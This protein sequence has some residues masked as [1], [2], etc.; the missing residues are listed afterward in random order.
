MKSECDDLNPRSA[1]AR[2]PSVPSFFTTP[3]VP[4]VS[5]MFNNAQW[6]TSKTASPVDNASV[7]ARYQ[8]YLANSRSE[9]SADI[10]NSSGT[11]NANIS[12]GQRLTEL[13][14]NCGDRNEKKYSNNT[15]K[16][17][18]A[19]RN[20]ISQNKNFPFETSKY[21]GEEDTFINKQQGQKSIPEPAQHPTGRNR[22]ELKDNERY[23]GWRTY[24]DSQASI[25][26]TRPSTEISRMENSS[27]LSTRMEMQSNHSHGNTVRSPTNRKAPPTAERC[28]EHS[29][30]GSRFC[31]LSSSKNVSNDKPQHCDISSNG[32]RT[33]IPVTEITETQLQSMIL[34]IITDMRN[35]SVQTNST[36]GN[37]CVEL[38]PSDELHS[39]I[40]NTTRNYV[41]NLDNSLHESGEKE[42]ALTGKQ[43]M[44]TE[45]NSQMVRERP[46]PKS[47]NVGHQPCNE[48]EIHS[49]THCS[50]KI[51]SEGSCSQNSAEAIV[52]LYELYHT[53]ADQ[54]K[55]MQEKIDKIII[56]QEINLKNTLCSSPQREQTNFS[57]E[58]KSH[59]VD[60]STQTNETFHREIAVGTEP[61][62]TASVGIMAGNI[63]LSAGCIKDGAFSD[64]RER[65]QNGTP[66]MRPSHHETISEEANPDESLC[67]N[68]LDLPS[69][70]M[71]VPSPMPSIHVDMQDFEEDDEDEDSESSRSS[72]G[73][74]QN[75]Q[76]ARVGWTFY[77]QVVGQVNKL[78]DNQTDRA[79][80]DDID[81]V[82]NV[83]NPIDKRDVR[84]AT[85]EQLKKLGI[86]FHSE[87]QDV[88][89]HNRAQQFDSM[90]YPRLEM[91]PLESENSECDNSLQI[92]ALAMK[93]MKEENFKETKLCNISMKTNFSFATLRYLE[94]YHLLPSNSQEGAQGIPN[95]HIGG[96][97]ETRK[98]PNAHFNGNVDKI[99]DITTI[100]NQPKLL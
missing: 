48:G 31:S 23:D 11:S 73:H 61:Q 74:L 8:E 80:N 51:T 16:S 24:F 14:R 27:A 21:T 69:V 72:S 33:Q 71:H 60:M 36:V 12:Q 1:P 84:T 19:S 56:L 100:K 9:L 92:N 77:N 26:E 35:T 67:L 54:L 65:F 43:N 32:K 94:R 30:I 41:Q 53:Q 95:N 68:S 52:N 47:S 57:S 78:L 42:L 46:P 87:D 81:N 85:L 4:E 45:Y 93:Y 88:P 55:I 98:S 40:V 63:G 50:E 5:L 22:R 76:T 99:L 64:K 89:V 18:E 91:R 37:K 83:V 66:Y 17:L 34:K 96:Q 75:G 15:F 97:F 39:S 13:S 10:I 59:M 25:H 86:S 70:R 49:K 79:K 7:N 28:E 3:S 62:E 38:N 90:H 20:Y 29:S 44:Q 6:L 58:R 2:S 82:V